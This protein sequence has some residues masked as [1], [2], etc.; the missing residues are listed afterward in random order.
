MIRGSRDYRNRMRLAVLETGHQ[1]DHREL[2][3]AK[4]EFGL[5]FLLFSNFGNQFQIENNSRKS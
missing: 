1:K 2:F 4:I 5:F 3:I